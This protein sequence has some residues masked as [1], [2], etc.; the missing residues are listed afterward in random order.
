MKRSGKF[1]RN[2]EK[3]VMHLL[4]LTP[5]PNSGSGWIVKEDGMSEN[6][7]CQLK[8]TDASS[9]TIN[10][11]D[12]DKLSYNATVAHKIP[13]FAIQYLQSNEI[14]LVIKPEDIADVAKYITTG[15]YQSKED[16]L[17]LDENI[18]DINNNTG[19]TIKS[20]AKGREKF[21]AELKDKFKKEVKLAR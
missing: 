13:V 16:F 2:N 11:L 21:D 9:I 14:F 19:K 12:T 7:L 1:Y 3:E 20:S 4:G 15:Q 17:G 6:I 10:K 8:S 18:E 5:T